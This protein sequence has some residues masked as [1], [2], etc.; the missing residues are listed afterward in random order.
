MSPPPPHLSRLRSAGA[1][2]SMY[3]VL[4]RKWRPQTFD[5]LV[6]QEHVARTLSNAIRSNRLAHAYILSGLRGTGKT[7][8]A[9]NLSV[10]LAEK[11]R[12]TLLI[13]LDPQGAIGHALCKSDTE[14]SGLAEYMMDG[15]AP[16][17]FL[18]ETKL[19]E[20]NILPRGRVDPVDICEY[21]GY[22]HSSNKLGELVEGDWLGNHFT[23]HQHPA[24]AVDI[25]LYTVGD[26]AGGELHAQC[27]QPFAISH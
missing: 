14:W 20:L 6:G 19:P 24:G 23:G 8:V 2:S 13:D 3:Q 5:K 9:L 11:H 17:E 7:T 26:G 18:V 10:A 15:G 21:E 22:L 1:D 25:G 4:A 16:E 12:R 27:L